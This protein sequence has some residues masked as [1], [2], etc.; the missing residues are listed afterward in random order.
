MA[1]AQ[2]IKVADANAHRAAQPVS[3]STVIPFPAQRILLPV[4]FA[5][6]SDEKTREQLRALLHS[7]LGVYVTKTERV[8]NEERIHFDIALA[9]LD[10]TL[11]TLIATLPEATIGR[12]SRQPMKRETR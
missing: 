2:S 6:E 12:I 4:T 11:H 1:F 9:D 10:F 8:R 7:P 3:R 5:R